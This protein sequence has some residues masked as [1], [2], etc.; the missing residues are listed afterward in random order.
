MTRRPGRTVMKSQGERM[1]YSV[2]EA[3]SQLSVSRDTVYRF[4]N[5]GVLRAVDMGI[6]R[7]LLRIRHDDLVAFIEGRTVTAA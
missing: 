5:A 7:Q 2:A 4:V 3:A 1:L 6:D